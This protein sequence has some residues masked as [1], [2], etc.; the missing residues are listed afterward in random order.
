MSPPQSTTT[1]VPA[2]SAAVEDAE[3]QRLFE[4][5]YH[6]LHAA[7]AA[8]HRR[9]RPGQTFVTTD[10][11]HEAYLRLAGDHERSWNDRD[12]FFK[13]AAETIR[14]ILIDRARRRAAVRRGGGRGREA[15]GDLAIAADPEPADLLALD[16]ALDRLEEEDATKATLVK[17]RYFGGLTIDEAAAAVGISHATAER[18]WKYS[19]ARLFQWIHGQHATPR[20]SD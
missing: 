7:A 2:S 14:R 6:D 11:V 9:E 19:R 4:L 16:E 3:S 18:Y 13:V 5:V 12:H 1:E 8:M 15:L 17:L 10:L 20:P